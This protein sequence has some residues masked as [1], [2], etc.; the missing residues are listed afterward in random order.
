MNTIKLNTIGTPKASGGNS[1]GGGS[2]SAWRYYDISALDIETK[3]NLSEVAMMGRVPSQGILTYGS[4]LLV[5]ILDQT[6]A[7][8]LDIN[9]KI[10]QEDQV[11]PISVMWEEYESTLLQL[12]VKEITEEEFYTL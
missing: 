1:G 11:V 12:G 10:L 8:S 6:D 3:T 7:F 2:A 4:L 5:N 9:C